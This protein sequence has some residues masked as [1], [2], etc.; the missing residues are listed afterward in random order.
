MD[1]YIEFAFN[2][3]LLIGALLGVLALIAW[4]EFKRATRKYRSLG[5]AE[6]VQLMNHEDTVLL[7]VR[8]DSEVKGGVIG[9]ARHITLNLLSKRLSELERFKDKTIVA[10]CRSGMRSQTACDVLTR[11]QFQKVVN[12]QGG[13]SAW[14]QAGLPVKKK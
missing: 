8:D 3:P 1:Q 2:H 14:E 4:T 7:D 9:G 10:Y 5:P 13:I 6:V 11:N 12:L